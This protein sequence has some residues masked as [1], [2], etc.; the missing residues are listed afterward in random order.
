MKNNKILSAGAVTVA[1]ALTLAAC[2][3]SKATQAA[4]STPA[5]SAAA[6]S[7]AGGPTAAGSSAAV[8]SPAAG[9]PVATGG[10]VVNISFWSWVPKIGEAVDKFNATHPNIH[11]TLDTVPGGSQGTYTKLYAAA[12]AGNAPDAAQIEYAFLPNFEQLGD[13]EDI[14]KYVTAATKSAFPAWTWSEVSNGSSVY[15]IPQDIAPEVLMYRTD[16][17]TAD[18][19]TTPPATWADFAADAKI[20]HAKDPNVYIANFPTNQPDWFTGLAWQAGGSWFSQTGGKWNVTIASDPASVKVAN[21]WQ[22]LI[23]SNVVKA[24]DFWTPAWNKEFSDGDLA[25]WITG[26]WGGPNLQ[27]AAPTTSG[28][29]AAAPL[30]QW[31]AGG[32]ATGNW[33]GSTNVVMKGAQHPAQAAEFISWLNTDPSSV[34]LLASD[35][36]LYVAANAFQQSASYQTAFPFFNGQ[37]VYSVAGSQTISPTWQWGPTTSDTFTAFQDTT[38]TLTAASGKITDALAAAQTKTVATMQQQGFP[39]NGS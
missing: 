18:G 9:S 33:G 12:Q 36:G 4:S 17:F 35:S 13:V 14:G 29:W 8:G 30:P 11:V 5:G 27:S 21:Y 34:A 38:G 2:S 39:V 1:V 28:K 19:I 31:T 25:A 22:G 16:I 32:T 3:S 24:E 7:S 20:I 23:S 37:K 15:A 6:T 10:P 26:A